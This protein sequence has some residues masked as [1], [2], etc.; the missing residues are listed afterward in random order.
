MVLSRN[1]PVVIRHFIIQNCLKA[2]EEVLLSSF[3]K[4][5]RQQPLFVSTYRSEKKLKL[6]L[7]SMCLILGSYFEDLMTVQLFSKDLNHKI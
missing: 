3:L 7:K 6:S 1:S 5:E 4:I 2:L